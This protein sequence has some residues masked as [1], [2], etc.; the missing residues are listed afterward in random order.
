MATKRPSS[1]SEEQVTA[2]L[3]RTGAPRAPKVA[4]SVRLDPLFRQSGRIGGT[5][6][7]KAAVRR[8]RNNVVSRDLHELELLDRYLPATISINSR[9]KRSMKAVGGNISNCKNAVST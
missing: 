9:N 4:V 8:Q 3:R 5:K 7:C 2:A 1:L 6:Q